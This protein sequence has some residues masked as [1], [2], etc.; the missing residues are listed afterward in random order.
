MIP[1]HIIENIKWEQFPKI[2]H[3]GG[4]SCGKIYSGATLIC[5]ELGF[6]ISCDVTKSQLKNKQLCFELFEEF[7]SKLNNIQHG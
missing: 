2:E 6:R 7:Y 5:E 1:K 4:Q 3:P